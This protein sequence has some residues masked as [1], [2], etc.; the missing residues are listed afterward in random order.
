MSEETPSKETLDFTQSIS[1]LDLNSHVD[2]GNS[3]L[4][5]GDPHADLVLRERN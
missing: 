3:L 4:A 1:C 5:V 2:D